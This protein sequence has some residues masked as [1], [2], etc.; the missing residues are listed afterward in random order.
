MASETKTE[1][2]S[3]VSSSDKGMVCWVDYRDTATEIVRDH[4]NRSDRNVLQVVES[5]R[6][7]YAR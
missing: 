2:K 6:T 5:G 4:G 3:A 1:I 7:E